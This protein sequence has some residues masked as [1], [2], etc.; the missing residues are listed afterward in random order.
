MNPRTRLLVSEFWEFIAFFVNSIVFLLIGDQIN[1]RGLADNGMLILVTI[2]ALVIVRAISIYGLGTISN[3]ITQQDISWQEE[4]VLW[5]GGVRG[6]VSIALALS[7]PVILESRQDIIEAVFGVVLFTL[8]VQGL[9]MQK[10]I[11]KLGLIGDRAQRRNYRELIA[12]RSALERVLQHLDAVKPSPSIDEEFK[13]YQR[14]LVQG[15]LES[16]NQEITQLQQSYPQ[17]RSLEQ[18]QLR[19][20]LLEVEADTY[21]EF[22]RAGKLNNNLSPLLQEVLAKE[23]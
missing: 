13:N 10:V 9:T 18:E 4:T 17:L 12:R 5:W 1:I 11:Q 22:I 19:D 3:L 2:V 23:D 6:S 14:G 8:L 20:Q 7:V 15:Q 21:A 16:V